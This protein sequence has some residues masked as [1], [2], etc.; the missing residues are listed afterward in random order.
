MDD[1]YDPNLLLGYV[2]DE[3]IAADRARV[4][5]MLAEDA[6]LAILVA[7]MKR[8]RDALRNAPPARL[9]ADLAEG[10]VATLE[11]QM[12]FDDEPGELAL[13]PTPNRRFRL[14]PLLTYG[15]IA[16][17]LTIT[18]GVVIQSL[19]GTG[20]ELAT[21]YAYEETARELGQS[22]AEATIE[23]QRKAVRSRTA[24][25]DN[26]GDLAAA[27]DIG[28]EEETEP[29][30][31]FLA[32]VDETLR[33]RPG[34]ALAQAEKADA[35]ESQAPSLSL[36]EADRFSFGANAIS[37]SDVSEKA[38]QRNAIAS[39]SLGRSVAEPMPVPDLAVPATAPVAPIQASEAGALS[40]PEI[41]LGLMEND[42]ANTLAGYSLTDLVP[43]QNVLIYTLRV[44]DA[45]PNSTRQL[46]KGWAEREGAWM[47]GVF[48]RDRHFGFTPPAD[49][50]ATSRT[51]DES[52]IRLRLIVDREQA[53]EL[54]A[55]LSTCGVVNSGL[56]AQ[57]P[58]ENWRAPF[59]RADVEVVITMPDSSDA[60]P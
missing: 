6:D 42:L 26:L 10:A 9:P 3:L 12:L 53:D 56:V 7:D 46:I 60:H 48:L 22:L 11:R 1:R 15:G 59:R 19:F 36:Q 25:V 34:S 4:E 30:E 8:D 32:T 18:V 24:G 54:V 5:A 23:A 44:V 43:D 13:P 47:S 33:Q 58:W 37:L 39:V 27:A 16:A 38:E 2:E 41:D 28:Q 45:S 50:L 29:L 57:R 14:A 55:F 40:G 20:K 51:G 49:D 21:S 52:L 31:S 35:T 17:V